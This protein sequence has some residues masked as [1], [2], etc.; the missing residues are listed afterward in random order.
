[1]SSKQLWGSLN[2]KLGG[3]TRFFGPLVILVVL[4]QTD[5]FLLSP[6]GFRH[7]DIGVAWKIER[8]SHSK[9]FSKPPSVRPMLQNV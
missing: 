5:D 3:C 1:M 9:S 7:G 2:L 8:I 6:C 4:M